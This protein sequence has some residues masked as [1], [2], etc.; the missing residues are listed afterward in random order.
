MLFAVDHKFPDDID[1]TLRK[2]TRLLIHVVGHIYHAHFDAVVRLDLVPHIN[3]VTYHLMS[4]AKAFQMVDD[5]DLQSL[6]DL[7]TELDH[8][9]VTARSRQQT[10]SFVNG[11]LSPWMESQQ[12]TLSGDHSNETV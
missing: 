8:S 9:A 7:Y 4:F 6:A 5:R 3:T 12:F 10:A 2:V 11:D 1:A